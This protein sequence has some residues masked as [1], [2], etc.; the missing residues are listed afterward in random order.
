[1]K[2]P[3]F[4][5]EN[6]TDKMTGR[7]QSRTSRLFDSSNEGQVYLQKPNSENSPGGKCYGRVSGTT[8]T[9]TY[10]SKGRC[11]EAPA[12]NKFPA[13]VDCDDVGSKC[14]DRAVRT[15]VLAGSGSFATFARS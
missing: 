7:F 2:I 9:G 3:G 10:D 12:P 14:Y 11:C 6:S 5:A 8:I 1:M 4:T 15:S 13:C